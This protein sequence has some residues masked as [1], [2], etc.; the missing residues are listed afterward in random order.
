L[1]NLGLRLRHRRADIAAAHVGGDDDAPLAVFSA[2][3]VGPLGK[4]EIGEHAQRQRCGDAFCGVRQGSGQRHRQILQDLDIVA[5][6]IGEPHD[7]LEAA[8][9]FEHETGCSAADRNA[10]H[11][12]HGGEAQA[13]PRD[14][15][16][17]DLDFQDRHP[18][19]ILDLDL[20]GAANAFQ[21]RS[22]LVG[23]APHRLRAPNFR[24]RS[25]RPG[26]RGKSL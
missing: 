8:V 6:H 4:I 15:G 18:R 11:V 17:V 23:G 22:D 19:H 9:A 21:D 12:L 16:L 25:A 14:L 26:R 3:L 10:D 1:G 20:A 5:R 7:D 24:R 13:M 2:H